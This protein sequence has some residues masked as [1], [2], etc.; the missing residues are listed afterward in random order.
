V[1]FAASQERKIASM[2]ANN[3]TTPRSRAEIEAVLG[4]RKI[5][6]VVVIGANGAMGYGSGALFTSAVARVTF[7]A[8]SKAKAEEGLKAAV[9]AVRSSTVRARVATGDYGEDFDAAVRKADLIFEALTEDFEI[10]RAMFER[11]DRI[12]R[13]DA[14]VATVTSGLSINALAAGRSDS[15]RKHFLGLH[16]FNP[17]NVIVGTELIAG[18]DTDPALVDF[19]DLYAQK[20]LGRKMIRTADTPG[21]AGNRVGF[22]VLNEAAQLAEVH[23]PVLV[24]KLL[25]PYTGRA[26]NP[27]ATVDLVGWDIHR[28]IVDNIYKNA[29]DE[30]RST[31]KLPSYMASMIEKGTLGTKSGGGFF[32]TEG[33]VLQAL[34]PKSGTYRPV[35]SIVLPDLGYIGA[36]ARLHR[37]GRY[38]EAMQVFVEAPGEYAALARKLVAGYISYAFH[39]VGEVTTSID[40]IDSIMGHGFNWAPPSV[41]VDTIGLPATLKMIDEAKLP[42]PKLLADAAKNNVSK[43]FYTNP[44]GN[45]GRFFVAG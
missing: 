18:K 20:Q 35:K 9:N 12:R 28:A 31:L 6:H 10:K 23:G 2:T 16:F 29:P 5:D 17:P 30:V 3:V 39:R 22:K 45:V 1:R 7:L 37:D 25:G 44:H 26:M 13:P 19:I 42:V 8:R 33:D 11:I 15:F 43:P 27:L 4:S 21:F 32:R 36:V 24:D 40:G 41:L 14:V 38:R 34:D